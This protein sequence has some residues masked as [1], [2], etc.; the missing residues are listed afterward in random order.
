VL[1]RNSRV[2]IKKGEYIVQKQHEHGMV[3]VCC[4]FVFWMPYVLANQ[5]RGES[6][7]L[8]VQLSQCTSL[9]PPPIYLL[10]IYVTHLVTHVCMFR[11]Q[12]SGVGA[13]Y[14]VRLRYHALYNMP[15]LK[16]R[17]LCSLGV[18]CT[19][20]NLDLVSVFAPVYTIY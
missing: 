16:L 8:S 18:F 4:E 19:Y 17:V 13:L 7:L 14:L 10:F 12:N 5:T 3:V 6:H 11:S 2:V 9:F 1:Q 15:A 20:L